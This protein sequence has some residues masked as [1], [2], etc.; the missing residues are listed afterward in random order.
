MPILRSNANTKY[1]DPPVDDGG[2]D[3]RAPDRWVTAA[4]FWTAPET[5]LARLKLE[6]EDIECQIVDENIVAVD[7]LYAPAV[8]GIKILVPESELERAR[9]LLARPSETSDEEPIGFGLCPECGSAHID[10]PYL[11]SKT[12]WA[13]MVALMLPPILPLSL[14][15]FAYYL[16]MWRPWRCRAC[17]NVFRRDDVRQGFPIK[18]SPVAEG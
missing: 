12:L 1:V 3:D 11:Q 9:A 2:D 18:P 6:S 16:V 14:A 13:G 7:F 8:G 4:T 15:G 10:R 5:H 17:G